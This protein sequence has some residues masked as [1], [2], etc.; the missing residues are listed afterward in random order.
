MSA[1]RVL[2]QLTLCR[3]VAL[4]T[5]SRFPTVSR[6]RSLRSSSYPATVVPT[7]KHNLSSYGRLSA[8]RI[9]QLSSN[10]WIASSAPLPSSS[11]EKKGVGR[12][13]AMKVA[14]IGQSLFGKEVKDYFSY[15]R[16]LTE[17]I[18]YV[19]MLYS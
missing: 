5:S 10:R 6:S 8:N 12:V 4:R 1:T 2:S 11:S 14:I 16:I 7:L 17:L 13:K 18:L 19:N 3:N 9:S 15:T